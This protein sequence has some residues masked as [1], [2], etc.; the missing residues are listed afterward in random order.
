M[1][2]GPLPTHPHLATVHGALISFNQLIN[3]L[4]DSFYTQVVLFYR[5]L[6]VC[7]FKPY[8]HTCLFCTVASFQVED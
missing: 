6:F 3:A 8:F 1:P 4:A 2:R 7:F 5:Y